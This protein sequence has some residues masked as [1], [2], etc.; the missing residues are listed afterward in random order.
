MP[1]LSVVHRFAPLS[2]NVSVRP[3]QVR[4]RILRPMPS[5]LSIG[6]RAVS[7]FVVLSQLIHSDGPHMR[8][9]FVDTWFCLDLPS[10]SASRRTPLV[11]ANS[12]YCQVCSGLSP[13]RFA[14]CWAHTRRQSRRCSCP[15]SRN[16][17]WNPDHS[18]MLR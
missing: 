1:P 6:T 11:S 7:D 17:I 16:H 2:G 15:C 18:K 13:P 12:S 9:L 4:V 3:P 14:P 10:D 8:F 5:H